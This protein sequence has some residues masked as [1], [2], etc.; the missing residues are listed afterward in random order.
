LTTEDLVIK[1]IKDLSN[2]IKGGKNHGGNTQIEAI[3]GLTDALHPGN[4]LAHSPRVQIQA[5]PR[6][7]FDAPPRVQ[8]DAPPRVQFNI[9]G[10]EEIPIDAGSPPQ[11]IVTSSTAST[12]QQ[13]LKSILK[14]QMVI[15]SESIADRVKRRRGTPSSSIA[16]RVAQRRQESANPVL[17]FDT[18]KLLNTASCY[19]TPSTKKSGPKQEQMNL[20]G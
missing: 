12:R 13:Q 6:V 2:A 10:N 8:F 20:A 4:Q 9:S 3:K 5:P 15:L 11:L 16:E 14:Q 18:G 1:A 19:G 7:Q 17:D